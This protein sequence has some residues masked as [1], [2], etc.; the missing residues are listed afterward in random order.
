MYHR[1][2]R[3]HGHVNIDLSIRFKQEGHQPG[4]GIAGMRNVEGKRGVFA[5]SWE[6]N[7]ARHCVFQLNGKQCRT[8][9]MR[10]A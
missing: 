9:Y 10:K 4:F 8:I 5:R 2:R 1:A 3:R 7:A 6:G